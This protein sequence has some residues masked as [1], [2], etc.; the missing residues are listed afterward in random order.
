MVQNGAQL[1]QVAAHPVR[2]A[3]LLG[4]AH[5]LHQPLQFRAVQRKDKLVGILR[6]EFDLVGIPQRLA[7]NPFAVHVGAV[8]TAAILDRVPA[9]LHHDARVRARDAAVADNEVALGLPP[10][11]ERQRVNRYARAVSVRVDHHQRRRF[12]NGGRSRRRFHSVWQC[13]Q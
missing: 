12:R 9:V 1:G 11:A 7:G 2:R 6:A 8:K 5:L 13:A 3:G 10:D 4:A